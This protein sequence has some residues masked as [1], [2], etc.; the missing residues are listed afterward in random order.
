M[1]EVCDF[2]LTSDWL[3]QLYHRTILYHLLR[4]ALQ[5]ELPLHPVQVGER[6]GR[7]ERLA[8]GQ[9][10]APVDDEV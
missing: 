5:I 7:D 10:V 3:V 9:S 8:A 2:L 1:S 6:E 4:D